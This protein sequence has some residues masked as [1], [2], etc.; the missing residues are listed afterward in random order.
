M[1]R[2]I[3]LL[4][5]VLLLFSAVSCG[6][7]SEKG[8]TSTTVTEQHIENK[9]EYDENGKVVKSYEY[10]ESGDVTVYISYRYDEND[11]LVRTVEKDYK[12]EKTIITDYNSD[13]GYIVYIC[14][15]DNVLLGQMEYDKD[16]NLISFSE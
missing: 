16:G 15:K 14:D 3:S 1:K 5:T 10:S 4:I 2:I 9:Y 8:T 13:G 7:N 11:N 6:N 12:T